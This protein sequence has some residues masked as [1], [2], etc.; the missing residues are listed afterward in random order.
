MIVPGTVL[1]GRWRVA[2]KI[3]QGKFLEHGYSLQ[4][5]ESHASSRFSRFSQIFCDSLCVMKRKYSDRLLGAFGEIFAA[6][7]LT[8]QEQTAIKVGLRCN[9]TP[10]P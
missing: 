9:F 6:V 4:Q 3:G 10:L 2:R 5:S 7:D 8:T 1:K